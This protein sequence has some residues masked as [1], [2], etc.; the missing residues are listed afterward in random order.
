[1]FAVSSPIIGKAP[2]RANGNE[3][4]AKGPARVQTMPNGNYIKK[5]ISERLLSKIIIDPLTG[6]WLW[7]A[8]RN[9]SGYGL[10]NV[11][12][13]SRLA[14]RESY[15]ASGRVIPDGLDLDH[16]C[17]KNDGSCVGG[18]ACLHRRCINPDHLEPVT[19]AENLRRGIH[20]DNFTAGRL[21]II[22]IRT[23]KTHCPHGHP[24]S[25]ENLIL[26]GRGRACLTC[27][28]ERA[29]EFYS[30]P[31]NRGSLRKRKRKGRPTA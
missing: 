1:M 11:D 14:H 9:P 28:K 6:C 22:A 10:I 31:E 3:A 26:T 23:A 25:G 4:R 24:Y 21:K 2:Y 30:R 17:H 5:T 27:S 13:K 29:R 8:C 12:R 19:N 20:V 7:S 16:T 18:N 15:V